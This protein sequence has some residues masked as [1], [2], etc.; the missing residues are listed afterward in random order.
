MNDIIGDSTVPPQC[1]LIT[2]IMV[3][4]NIKP[5][6]VQNNYQVSVQSVSG[7]VPFCIFFFLMWDRMF[8]YIVNGDHSIT[9]Y[10]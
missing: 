7:L 6:Q 10:A 3:S 8:N 1:K 2:F 9:Y 5:I 4:I